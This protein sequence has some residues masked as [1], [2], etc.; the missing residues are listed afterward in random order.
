[1]D[2]L[3]ATYASS[4]EDEDHHQPIPSKTTPSSSSLSSSLPPPKSS[5][6]NFLPPP[7]QPSSDTLSSTPGISSLPKPKSQIHEKP[8]R[9]VQFKPPI[10]PLPKPNLEDD[11]DDDDEEEERNRRRKL[12]SS[13]QTPSVKSFLSTIPAPRNSSTLGIQSISGSGRRSILETTTPAPA[14]RPSSGGGSIGSVTA[15]A[16]SNVHEDQN[17]T[18]YENYENYQYATDQYDSYGNYQYAT[19]HH[20][21]NSGASTGTASNGDGYANYGAYEGYGQYENKWVDRSDPSAPEDSG[22][23]ESVLKFTGKR[24]RKEVPV[25]VIEVKQDELMKN[26][27]RED[28]AKLTGL[29]FGPSYQPVS[30]K[31]KPSKLMKRKHQIGSLYFDMKQNEMKLAERRSKGMLTKAETQAKYGW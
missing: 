14:P 5:L 29:A 17:G 4:D 7:K 31:G 19:D 23:S 16:E 26:R 11:E 21:D 27:P 13:I 6:F 10:I 9:V 20:Y 3:L 1:M 25:E 22:I 15:T 8:K 30:A 28:K 18:D 2:S 12:E 24:G